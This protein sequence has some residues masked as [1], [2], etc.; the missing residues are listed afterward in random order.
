MSQLHA[1]ACLAPWAASAYCVEQET[2]YPRTAVFRDLL[3]LLVPQHIPAFN[4][5][6]P[7]TEETICVLEL[8]ICA[9]TQ[10]EAP[11]PAGRVVCDAFVEHEMSRRTR[12]RKGSRLHGDSSSIARGSRSR[13]RT[14]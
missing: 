8:R 6:R 2:R 3:E 5:K 9:K 14:Q 12:T 13:A 11:S 1:S 4:T 10:I 7:L